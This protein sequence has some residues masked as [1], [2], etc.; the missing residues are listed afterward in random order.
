MTILLMS[1]LQIFNA[2]PDLY[3]GKA[4]NFDSPLLSMG[5]TDSMPQRGV[6]KLF[7]HSFDTTGV[8]GLSNFQGQPTERGF[9]SWSTL[10]SDQDLATGRRWHFLFAWIFV[11]N[12]L[13]YVG[14]GLISGQL[15]FRL[16]P[17]LDQIK[18]FG[19]AVWEH[20][21]LRFPEGQEAKRY[22]VI[23]KLTY[24]IVIVGLL[25]IQIL[26]GLA[27]SPGFDAIAP[28]ILDLFGGRQSARTVHFVVA[29]LLVL[30]VLVH[31]VLVVV[32]GLWNNMRGMISGW[33][34]IEG[35]SALRFWPSRRMPD[36]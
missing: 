25:P 9:P 6:T 17:S 12:G 16:I 24:L 36:A 11:L 28:W 4:S 1:G 27:M 18:G 22:N 26:A 7:G 10:P 14:Y 13:L 23:Q 5:A 33:F 8:L 29:A 31:V 35:R 34:V 20:L 19:S 3:F 2:R 32:S 15:R 30:F 21:R